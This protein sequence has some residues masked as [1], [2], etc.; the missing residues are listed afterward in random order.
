[1]RI[2]S[3]NDIVYLTSAVGQDCSSV[4][5][6][7]GWFYTYEC[8]DE[9][10]SYANKCEVMKQYFPCENGCVMELGDDV[11]AYVATI[12]NNYHKCVTTES[13][14]FMCSGSHERTQRLCPCTIK[15]AD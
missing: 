8:V 2:G 5:D 12:G 14:T 3:Q 1:M 4:C 10:I 15:P 13:T 7:Y 11:P 9:Y 6:N